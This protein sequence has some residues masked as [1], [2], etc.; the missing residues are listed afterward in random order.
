MMCIISANFVKEGYVIKTVW[1]CLLSRYVKILLTYI[2]V[3]LLPRFGRFLIFL[4][5]RPSA[6]LN[7]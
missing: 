7:F 2:S 4:R 5:W 1:A 3:V 6:I